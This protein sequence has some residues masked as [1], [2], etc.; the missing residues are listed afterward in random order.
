MDHADYLLC[1][2]VNFQA[3]ENINDSMKDYQLLKLTDRSYVMPFLAFCAFATILFGIKL[4]LIGSYGNATPFWDQWNAEAERLYHP[5]YAGTLAWT[6]LFSTHNEHRIFTTRLLSLLL[7]TVNGI[8]NPLLQMV[9]NAVLHIIAIGLGIL[10]LTRVLGRTHLPTLLVFSLLL[11]AVPYAWENTLAGFQSQFYFVLLFSIASLW[12]TVI[13]PPLSI[14]WW[15]GIICAIFAF[16]SLASGIFALAASA[17]TG[18]V[19]YIAGLRKSFKQLVAVM[20]LAAMFILG[21]VLTPSLEYHASYKAASFS[22]FLDALIAI[23]SWPISSNLFSML[24]RN[25]PALCFAGIMLW[26]RPPADN[27]KWFLFALVVWVIGQAFSI[28][29]GRAVG[30]LSSRYL[31][32]FAIGILVNFACLI[33]IIQEFISGRNIWTMVGESIWVITIM[34]SL[35]LSARYISDELSSKREAGIAQEINTKNYLATGDINH[36]KDKPFLHVPYPDA[37]QL[38]AILA[39]PAINEILPN[40]ISRPLIHTAIES[41]PP[42]AFIVDGYFPATPK[43]DGL[44]LGS[45]SAQGDLATGQAT[46]TFEF[47]NRNVLLAIPVAGYPLNEDIKLEVEQNGQRKPVAIRNNPKESWGT[48]YIR[49]NQGPFSILISDLSSA[50]TGWVAVGVPSVAGRLDMITRALLLYFPLF[51]MAGLAF[52]FLLLKFTMLEIKGR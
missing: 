15:G 17:C 18:L 14:G 2:R 26:K 4:W 24:I 45:Y 35:G 42:D 47:N 19:I 9:V 7:L 11:F 6:D 37:E 21:F 23:L 48:G 10:L 41:A 46:L 22:Q 44:T 36:L 16:L 51:I 28:A 39:L 43:R 40:N 32:L 49:V 8:W 34:I 29:Y 1:T 52:M 25:L 31:D 12:L 13:R 5:L 20:I 38:A 3:Y 30:H 27:R 50:N 33:S